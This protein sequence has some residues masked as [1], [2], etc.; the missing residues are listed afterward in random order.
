MKKLINYLFIGLITLT[1][2]NLY[3]CGLD[4]SGALPE[5]DLWIPHTTRDVNM[6]EAEFNK[7]TDDI[8]DIYRPII[9]S[10]GGRLVMKKKWKDGTVNAYANRSLFGGWI[11][12]MFGGLARHKLITKDGYAMVVCHEI[13]HHIAG[14]P[15][16]MFPN[17]WASVEGQS[18]YWGAM[19]CFREY[20]GLVNNQQY[21]KNMDIDPTARRDCNSAYS[22]EEDRAICMRTAM[23]GYSLAQLLRSLKAKNDPNYPEIEFDTP[24][25]KVVSKTYNMHPAAQCRLDTYYAGALCDMGQDQDVS[26][27]DPDQGVCNRKLGDKVGVRPLCWF[28]PKS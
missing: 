20:A 11:V 26:N 17:N 9:K 15:K 23:A 1:T 12:N 4:G 3:A 10:K 22:H 24:D 2:P 16:N 19:K 7:I 18:D 8:A 27:K 14:T 13:G 28:K 5:N 21:I 25:T 6:T